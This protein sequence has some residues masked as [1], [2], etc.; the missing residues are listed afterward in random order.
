M[1]RNHLHSIAVF[2][3]FAALV[4]AAGCA[5][6][7]PARP[8][9]S[10]PL[11]GASADL[12]LRRGRAFA[13]AGDTIRAEQYLVAA[14]NRGAR[15]DEVLPVLLDVCIRGQR[16]RAALAHAERYLTGRPNDRALLQMSAVL[17]LATGA[18]EKARAALERVVAS[19]P[20][21]AETR[22]LLAVA[23]RDLGEPDRADSQFRLYLVLAPGGPRAA[24]ASAWLKSEAS[25]EGGAPSARRDRSPRR[26]ERSGRRAERRRRR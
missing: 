13:A 16:Y 4:S 8:R 10:D 21:E 22:Y 7:P 24:E 15:T 14:E 11:A 9:A 3:A 17:Y 20:N 26:G 12:L 1:T 18:P 5:H 19:A 6:G 23:H 2:G 25:A